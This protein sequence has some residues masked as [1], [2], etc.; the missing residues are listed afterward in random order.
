MRVF[1]HLATLLPNGFKARSEVGGTI[2]SQAGEPF[3]C[4]VNARAIEYD[5]GTAEG[6]WKTLGSKFYQQS[7]MLVFFFYLL[8]F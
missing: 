4:E 1:S 2:P 3:C 7:L 8:P 6:R 5:K